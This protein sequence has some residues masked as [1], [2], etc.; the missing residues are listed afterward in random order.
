M[1]HPQ[2][3][4]HRFPPQD[5]FVQV[6]VP[7]RTGV[8]PQKTS[9]DVY[10]LKSKAIL[11]SDLEYY[12]LFEGLEGKFKHLFYYQKMKSLVI[13]PQLEQDF[14]LFE[15]HDLIPLEPT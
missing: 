11:Q 9:W 5:P 4:T 10:A 1:C 2:A 12:F 7:S 8:A 3:F 6:E 14:P 13:C 15:V